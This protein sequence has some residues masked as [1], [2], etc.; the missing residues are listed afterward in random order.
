MSSDDDIQ[1]YEESNNYIIID[2]NHD[3]SI[4]I[5]MDYRTLIKSHCVKQWA[6]NRQ[7]S[8]NVIN[9]LYESITTNNNIKW[10]L[11][12]FKERDSENLYLID[13]QHRYE[14]IK[15]KI[16]EDIDMQY[17]NNIYI[18]IYLIDNKELEVN[19]IIDLFNKI[20]KNTPLNNID[21]PDNTII[22]M[23]E[24]I[25]KDPILKNGIKKNERHHSSHQ[26]FIHKK[27]LNELLQ[28]NKEYIIDMNIDDIIRNLK[29]INNRLSLMSFDE[30]YTKKSDINYKNWCKANNIQFVL[31]L[32]DC[33]NNYKIE[34][35]IKNI[36]NPELIFQL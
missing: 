8:D 3:K 18:I 29:I 26:P 13:G 28:N 4:L 6:Y 34:N 33:K 9:E 10:T 27:T 22:N 32:R 5:K 24:K 19:Y 36:R 31:G 15:R 2:E 17:I 23:V 7:L 25:I 16:N 21:Y 12:A 30:I 20:N 35:I 11:T 1:E 14:A